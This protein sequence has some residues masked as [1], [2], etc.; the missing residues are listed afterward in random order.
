MSHL[1]ESPGKVHMIS[2]VVPCRN[3]IGAIERFLESILKQDLQGLQ[4]EVIVADG[5]SDDG[6]HEILERAQEKHAHIRL[7]DNPSRIVSTGLNAAIYAARGDIIVRMDVHTEYKDDYIRRCVE[8]LDTTRADNVGGAC[9]AKGKGYVG[10]AIAAAFQCAFAV[11]GARWHRPAHKG[12]VDTVHLGCWRREVLQQIGFFDESLV[13]NQDDELNLRIV[14]AGGT[15]WQAPEI[16]S[17]YHPRSSFASL[18]RQY[19]Q[20]GFWKVAVIRKHRLPASWRHL[21]PGAFVLANGLFLAALALRR[22]S[23]LAWPAWS[24]HF[25]AG[26]DTLYVCASLF[27]AFIT[28]R[29]KGWALFPLLPFV[30]AI[31]HIAYGLGFLAGTVYFTTRP[32]YLTQYDTVFT[33]LTR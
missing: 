21:V 26:M 33:R 8:V 29:T 31:Y 3:E 1:P 12:P 19:F 7:I 23:M 22:T 27:F 6:T 13:R 25:G 20:Y 4:Y 24:A 10:S 18:F 16:V 17:W 11:G 30:F 2:I 15:I 28:A 32:R 5:M 14:R 9:I